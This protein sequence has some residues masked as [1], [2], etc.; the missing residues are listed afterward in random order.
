MSFPFARK[1]SFPG[2]SCQPQVA[3]APLRWSCGSF[4][5]FC[6]AAVLVL[7]APVCLAAD[8]SPLDGFRALDCFLSW[9]A[10]R[11]AAATPR[12]FSACSRTA[13]DSDVLRPAKAN[14][15]AHPAKR[16]QPSTGFHQSVG[17]RTASWPWTHCRSSGATPAAATNSRGYRRSRSSRRAG[18]TSLDRN[19]WQLSR[20]IFPP[21]RIFD[22]TS[23][24][25][26]IVAAATKSASLPNH[27]GGGFA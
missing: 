11:P 22:T 4:W 24:P 20:V 18:R 7:P 16:D 12:S 17:R 21:G 27:S 26:L 15:S 6:G 19:R 14:N 23:L 8:T 13:S 3:L 1:P 10:N 5:P 2:P 9:F 25:S